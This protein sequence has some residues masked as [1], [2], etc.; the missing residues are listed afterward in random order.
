MQKLKY[1]I[2]LIAIF[3]SPAFAAE[4][5]PSEDSIRQLLAITGAR[6]L[7]D[8]TI[9]QI[10]GMLQ[11]TAQAA[12]KGQ[13]ITPERQKI[14]DKTRAKTIVLLKEELNWD[15][16]EHIYI[17]IYR[18]SFTQKEIDGL[19]A[20]YK[21]PSGQALIKKMPTVMQ[22]TMLEVQKLTGRFAQQFQEIN[23][24]MIGELEA[25]PAQQHP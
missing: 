11:D 16:L 13:P 20:F 14:I 15:N 9:G 8:S 10:D 7:V 21:T 22:Q 18:N 1:I 23:Q 19:I 25:Q 12:L 5:K 4:A 24:E 2:F 6:K 17:E 3:T